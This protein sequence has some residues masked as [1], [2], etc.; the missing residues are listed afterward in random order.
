MPVNINI[1]DGNLALQNSTPDMVCALLY[2][3]NADDAPTVDLF[4]IYNNEPTLVTSY[5]EVK[6]LYDGQ[7]ANHRAL[8][9]GWIESVKDFFDTN[10]NGQVWLNQVLMYQPIPVTTWNA[11]YSQAIEMTLTA[12]DGAIRNFAVVFEALEFSGEHITTMNSLAEGWTSTESTPFQFWVSMKKTDGGDPYESVR[13]IGANRCSV[14]I[15]VIGEDWGNRTAMGYILGMK[16]LKKVHE[17]VG[18]VQQSRLPIAPGKNIMLTNGDSVAYMTNTDLVN[19]HD[20]GY[21]FIR[22][23]RNFS[24]WYVNNAPM[25]VDVTS[26]FAFSQY[27]S[28]IDKAL[29]LIR[30]YI[31]PA[32]NAPVYLTIEGQ[33]DENT[34]AY[35]RGLAEKGLNQMKAAGEIANFRNVEVSFDSATE[36]ITVNV[37]ILRVNTAAYINV[38]LGFTL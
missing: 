20:L 21:T 11:A 38:N 23:Y 36:T 7:S 10:P 25:A 1:T 33:L 9:R 29:R 37:A 30:E 19:L 8:W 32:E 15:A 12:A 4:P 6:A 14:V 28:T 34:L 22:N 27:R 2:V 26:D 17:S 3:L 24:G 16:S 35:F 5:K 18:F 13:Q 31:L